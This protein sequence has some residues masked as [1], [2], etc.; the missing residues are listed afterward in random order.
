MKRCIVVFALGL[1]AGT[2]V[3]AYNLWAYC[4]GRCTLRGFLVIGPFEKTMIGL[5]LVAGLSLV[6]LKAFRRRQLAGRRCN[7]GAMLS[8][9]WAFCPECGVS[10]R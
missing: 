4:C 5:T 6:A 8:D 3:L 1:A 10:R 9:A 7:C 2:A